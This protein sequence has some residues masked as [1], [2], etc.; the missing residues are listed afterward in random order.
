MVEAGDQGNQD[1]T[2]GNFLLLL[3][4]LN[5][6]MFQSSKVKI[7]VIRVAPTTG[8]VTETTLTMAPKEI[9]P[10]KSI[11]KTRNNLCRVTLILSDLC[12]RK[13][14]MSL[15]KNWMIFT[16]LI[17]VIDQDMDV[18]YNSKRRIMARLTQP[19]QKVHLLKHLRLIQIKRMPTETQL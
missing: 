19:K 12:L 1:K 3:T 8:Q 4:I 2:M 6:T 9:H 15:C 11:S 16:C 14:K 7:N 10:K 18:S 17:L 5:L 13:S